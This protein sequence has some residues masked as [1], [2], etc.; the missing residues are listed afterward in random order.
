MSARRV[1]SAR[2]WP[3]SVSRPH[4]PAR[5]ILMIGLGSGSW[6]QV[7]ANLPSTRA[8]TVIELNPAYTTLVSGNSSVASLLRNPR[9]TIV[10]DDG[11][12]WLLRHDIKFDFI[13]M[14]TP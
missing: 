12:R 1:R 7:V 14:N 5:E 8:L 3:R 9:V 4:S 6:A 2:S 11:R 13:V 10:N